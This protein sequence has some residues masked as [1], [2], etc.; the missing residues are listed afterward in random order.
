VVSEAPLTTCGAHHK[1]LIETLA[2]EISKCPRGGGGG[3]V[4]VPVGGVGEL[5]AFAR[6]SGQTWF[7][8][9]LNGPTERELKIPLTFLGT[10]KYQVLEARDKPENSAAIGM[11]K[12][13][14]VRG[15]SGTINLPARG[16]FV[17]RLTPA[18]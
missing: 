5:A 10:S 12:N 15:D 6:R 1:S 16:G 4:P 7:L 2:V 3:A 17:G 13:V 11:K 14:A 18:P 9:V 8:G